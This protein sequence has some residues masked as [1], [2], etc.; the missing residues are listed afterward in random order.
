MAALPNSAYGAI[1]NLGKENRMD[2]TLLL[3]MAVVFAVII[4]VLQIRRMK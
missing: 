1:P 2:E 4:A 3:T